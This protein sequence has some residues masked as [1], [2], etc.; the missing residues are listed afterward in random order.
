MSKAEFEKAL[1]EG[2]HYELCR[3]Y[4]AH[5]TRALPIR[6]MGSRTRLSVALS[7][8]LPGSA[9][10]SL[11]IESLAAEVPPLVPAGERPPGGTGS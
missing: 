1:A 3:V 4:E 5:T 10:V 9:M 8:A 6:A 11:D 2:D 7:I